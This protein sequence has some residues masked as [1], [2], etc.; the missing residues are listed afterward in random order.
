MVKSLRGLTES[1]Q[2]KYKSLTRYAMIALA[3]SVAVNSTN[4]SWA[5]EATALKHYDNARALERQGKLKEAEAEIRN[6]M[7]KDPYDSMNFIKLASILSQ[8]GQHNEA[9]SW[10]KRAAAMDAQDSMVY[11]S[12]GG[13]YEQISDYPKAEEA[14]SR[15]L[16][17][18]P[19][20]KFGLLNLA[21]TQTQQ[22]QNN[23]E[24]FKEAIINYEALLKD[25]PDHFESRRHL[26]HL[27]L[28][29]ANEPEAVKQFER[30][31]TDFPKRFNDH[32]YLAKALTRSNEPQKALE[33]LKLAYATEGSKADIA[34]EMG[35]AHMAL[36]QIPYA[37]LNFEKAMTLNPQKTELSLQVGDLY[38][39]TKQW[40]QAIG[41][42]QQYLSKHPENLDAHHALAGAFI[43]KK[44]FDSALRELKPLSKQLSNPQ[45]RFEVNK[46]IAFS[47]QMLGDLDEAIPR[48][49]AVVKDPLSSGDNQL[50][51]NLAIA[52]HKKGDL[53]Q[54]AN[55]YKE[56]Y[57]A[58][59]DKNKAVA[60]DLANV[61]VAMGDRLYQSKNFEGAYNK[62][63]EAMPFAANNN[64]SPL[65]GLANTYYIQLKPEQA[66][67]AYQKVLEKDPH[68]VV[69]KLYN[70]KLELAKTDWTTNP[71][72]SGLT[73]L[74]RL[75]DENRSN[76]EVQ[77]VLAETYAASGDTTRSIAAYEKAIALQPNNEHLY[78]ALGN[79]WDK[80]GQHDNA[81]NA[82]QQAIQVNPQ[83]AVVHYNLGTLF[84]IKGQYRE[85][86][87]AYEKAL[88]IDP[89]FGDSIYGLAVSQEKLDRY[90]DA[91]T[92]Y[93]SYAALPTGA[94]QS[95]ARARIAVLKGYFNNGKPEEKKQ[96]TEN[97]E[98]KVGPAP[99]LPFSPE[100]TPAGDGSFELLGPLTPGPDDARPDAQ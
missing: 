69:A 27:Q 13:L 7:A 83:N 36:N 64:V 90:R 71:N 19:Q 100:N 23:P 84:Q 89:T 31:K 3:I 85:S 61:I 65:L 10:Y 46:E 35:N 18:N 15:A 28:V 59:P 39:R 62:Y 45:K 68:N 81:V 8:L 77:T 57:Q 80:A 94:Y 97:V 41:N 5:I 49:E 75:A 16:K 6:A 24:K 63:M 74:Q 51:T 50:R 92:N 86:I 37:I 58:D 60:N 78:I 55:L 2:A 12:L 22:G 38:L 40:D 17:K 25:Y 87:S 96:Q 52:Y 11:Y 82:Y 30:L 20:Y 98:T 91:L 56:I 70:T 21:R 34:E 48:Y 29:V 67:E 33:E 95:Q 4:L 43:E 79:Q 72:P 73:L 66:R 42:Y 53:E 32:L 54:A 9:I 47:Y 26:A 44:D 76:A 1:V 99:I 93:E 14:Y 88:K